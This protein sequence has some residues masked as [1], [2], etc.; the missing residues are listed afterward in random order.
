[1]ISK[2]LAMWTAAALAFTPRG[3]AAGAERD[4]DGQQARAQKRA[5]AAAGGTTGSQR[6]WESLASLKKCERLIGVNKTKCFDAVRK[7][8]GQTSWRRS[9]TQFLSDVSWER[10]NTPELPAHATGPIIQM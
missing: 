5:D 4:F 10:Q 9:G 1:M 8:S 7:K 2:Q 3:F 6:D